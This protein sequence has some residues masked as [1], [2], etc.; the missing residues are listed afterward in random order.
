M[1][2]ELTAVEIDTDLARS[3]AERLGGAGVRVVQGDGTA[4]PF[5]SGSFTAALSFT[6]LHHVP[7]SAQQDALLAEVA[8]VLRPGGVLAGVDSLDSEA[9]RVLHVDDICVPI[10]PE[11]FEARLKAAGFAE[12][13]V[14]P[15]PY[16][17]Q[18]RAT[19]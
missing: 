8:R 11:M 5:P 3:L 12:A 19:K 17:V 10:E 7:S 18:F 15:N 16:V 13:H 6:M 14:E 1:T 2:A 4:L 9:F